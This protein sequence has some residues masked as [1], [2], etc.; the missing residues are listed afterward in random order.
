VIARLADQKSAWGV[1]ELQTPVA[2]AK[3]R[4]QPVEVVVPE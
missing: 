1:R 3:N 4:A 2:D